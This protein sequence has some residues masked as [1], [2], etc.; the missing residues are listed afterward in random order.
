MCTHSTE[1]GCILGC[2]QTAWA[3]GGGKGFCP[4]AL[5]SPYLQCCVQLWS[6]QHKRAMDLLE[7]I[8]RRTQQ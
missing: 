1:A 4:S 8:Q 2:I 5:V 3:A 6:P 7:L